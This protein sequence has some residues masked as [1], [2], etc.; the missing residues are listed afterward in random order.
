MARHNTVL[1]KGRIKVMLCA[2]GRLKRCKKRRSIADLTPPARSQS[3]ADAKAWADLCPDT[4]E[5][6][7]PNMPKPKGKMASNTACKKVDGGSDLAAPALP[8]SCE[9]LSCEAPHSKWQATAEPSACGSE[10]VAARVTMD[11]LV[12]MRH[13]L[14]ITLGASIEAPSAARGGNQS[15]ALS[16]TFPSST[17]KKKHQAAAWRCTCEACAAGTL[18]LSCILTK[19]SAAGALAKASL[20]KGC[21]ALVKPHFAQG[22]S[23]QGECQDEAKPSDELE[24]MAEGING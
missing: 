4:R 1:C 18:E 10:L 11:L 3:K 13:K 9:Q 5:E 19:E 23:E 2:F 17:L 20:P 12:E 15:A 14:Q 21:S 7:S 24:T 8:R 16:A 22:A 6:L